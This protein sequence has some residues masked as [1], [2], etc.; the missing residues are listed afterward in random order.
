M[1]IPEETLSIAIDV[2]KPRVIPMP[3]RYVRQTPP[4]PEELAP[5]WERALRSLP[6]LD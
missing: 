6:G 2:P 3:E 1:V 5:W 4:P